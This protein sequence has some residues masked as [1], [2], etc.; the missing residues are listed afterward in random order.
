M[1]RAVA[2]A[3]RALRLPHL[4]GEGSAARNDDEEPVGMVGGELEPGAEMA[5]VG[6]AAAKLQH[7]RRERPLGHV[8][9]G[10]G[11]KAVASAAEASGRRRSISTPTPA[12]STMTSG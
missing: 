4:L 9:L 3:E 8:P 5:S 6:E 10:S 12:A 11:G 2:E 1:R 7:E